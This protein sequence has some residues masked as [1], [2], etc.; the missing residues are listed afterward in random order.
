[1]AAGD[2]LTAD[3]QIEW[4]GTLWGWPATNVGVTDFSGWFGWTL[5]GSNA[6]RPARHGTFPG[7]KRAN[8]RVVEVEL[9]V[10]EEDTSALAAIRAATAYAEDPVEEELV[11]W[12]GTDAPQYVMAR[13]ERFA[14]PTDF[15]WSVGHHRATLQWVA[16]DPRRYSVAEHTSSLVGLPAAGPSGL[17]F[18]LTFPLAFGTGSASNSTTVNNVGDSPT[19]PTFVITGPVTGPI[20]TNSTTG[21]KLQFASSFEVEAGQT[22]TIDTDSRSVTVD[23]VGRNGDLTVREWFP[24]NPGDTGIT[25]AGTGAY[26]PAAGLTVRWRDCFS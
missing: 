16:S 19:W 17:T 20:V 23:G 15:D 3:L 5:R 12:A 1:M 14:I 4:R 10:F 8:E 21:R 9:T 22:M 26:D 2:L 7:R 24:L 18:P 6:E 13:L 25:F 11:V